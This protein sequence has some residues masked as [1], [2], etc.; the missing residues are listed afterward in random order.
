MD[1]PQIRNWKI[2]KT[3]KYI[4]RVRPLKNNCF[5]SKVYGYYWFQFVCHANAGPYD[6]KLR[7]RDTPK[8]PP[9]P[10][11]GYVP[12]PPPP[13]AAGADVMDMEIGASVPI[14]H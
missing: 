13:L 14:T 1:E 6:I 8:F 10:A 3:G 4:A 2:H 12:S 11:P 9:A 7:V 5:L